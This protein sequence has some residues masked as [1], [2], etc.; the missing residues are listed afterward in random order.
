MLLITS[1]TQALFS[2]RDL[3]YLGQ[4]APAPAP[5]PPTSLFGVGQVNPAIL[6]NIFA[7]NGAV[8]AAAATPRPLYPTTS[9]PTNPVNQMSQTP[10]EFSRQQNPYLNHTASVLSTPNP[11]ALAQLMYGTSP[12]LDGGQHRHA[13]NSA[14]NPLALPGVGGFTGPFSTD[15]DCLTQ[16]AFSQQQPHPQQQQQ[17]I[18]AQLMAGDALTKQ[19]TVAPSVW[20]SVFPAHATAPVVTTSVMNST[21]ASP[22]F[23]MVSGSTANPIGIG[24][25]MFEN[26]GD[27]TSAAAATAAQQTQLRG[28]M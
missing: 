21:R 24:G 26:V 9:N 14:P 13:Y 1:I 12:W 7:L 22:A 28:F 19:T 8:A 2:P 4:F 17:Q 11:F 3:N 16:G 18:A 15:V 5:A 23:A 20:P 10:T 6:S 25:Q 27:T